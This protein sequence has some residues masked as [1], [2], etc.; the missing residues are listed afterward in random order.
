MS[1][2]GVWLLAAAASMWLATSWL[3][4]SLPAHWRQVFAA[5]ETAPG[6]LRVLGWLALVV[7]VLCCFQADHPSMAVLVWFTLLPVAAV[8]TA[9]TLSYRPALLRVVCPAFLRVG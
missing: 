2:A 3:A 5:G 6:Y 9:M 4:L 8:A 1:N 7:S